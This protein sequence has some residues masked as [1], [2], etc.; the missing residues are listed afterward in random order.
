M[1]HPGKKTQLKQ[2]R[3]DATTY[4]AGGINQQTFEKAPKNTLLQTT[5]LYKDLNRLGLQD[6]IVGCLTNSTKL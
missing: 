3:K 6:K 5:Y 4:N 2:S 1:Q